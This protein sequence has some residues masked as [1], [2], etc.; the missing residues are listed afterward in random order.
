MAISPHALE[1]NRKKGEKN[2]S[3]RV[4]T[5]QRP[6]LRNF[7]TGMVLL[8][9]LGIFV[10][11]V[12]SAVVVNNQRNLDKTINMI[13]EAGEINSALRFNI[14]ELE[15]APRIYQ[16]AFGSPEELLD[17]ENG[18]Y[19]LGMVE[20]SAIKYLTASPSLPSQNWNVATISE[21]GS[22]ANE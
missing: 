5:K 3:L 21:I 17:E 22:G 7:F 18:L 19:G 2:P 20:P 14:S 12:F 4:L 1:S 16:I 9:V 15:S 10:R 8:F 11:V 13:S 6:W